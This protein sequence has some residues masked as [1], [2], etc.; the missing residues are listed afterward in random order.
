MI[1][2]SL[3][4]QNEVPI[5]KS[6]IGGGKIKLTDYSDEQEL[7]V[8]VNIQSTFKIDITCFGLNR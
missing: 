8:E 7:C 3:T 4:L 5:M 1:M 2:T 6:L